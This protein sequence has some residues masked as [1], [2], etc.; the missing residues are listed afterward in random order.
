VEE[1]LVQVIALRRCRV[2]G[3]PLEVPAELANHL[4]SE[5]RQQ[6]VPHDLLRSPTYLWGSGGTTIS[7]H[8]RSARS[9][10]AWRSRKTRNLF[11]TV[12]RLSAAV[13]FN[14]TL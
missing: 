7:I 1:T 12:Y 5:R 10:G 9:T 11:S 3:G 2:G 13:Q 8:A 6:L 14:T 4:G